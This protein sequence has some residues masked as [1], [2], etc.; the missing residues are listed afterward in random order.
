MGYWGSM[1]PPVPLSPRHDGWTPEKQWR[2]VEALAATASIT[3]AARMVGMSV[4]SAQR[5]RRHPLSGEF[6]AAALA[7]TPTRKTVQKRQLRQLIQIG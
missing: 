5:L 6:R 4:R 2:F 3:Q 1:S 7:V